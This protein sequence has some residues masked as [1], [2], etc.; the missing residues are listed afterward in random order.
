MEDKSE[1]RLKSLI[2]KINIL[3]CFNLNLQSKRGFVPE[4]NPIKLLFFI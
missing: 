3:I 2:D 4:N 1:F